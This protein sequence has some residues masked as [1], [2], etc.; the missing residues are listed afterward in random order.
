MI[1][2]PISPHQS[3]KFE[4]E[5]DLQN[6]DLSKECGLWVFVGTNNA[7][8]SVLL[9]NIQQYTDG[10][11]ISPS[12]FDIKSSENIPSDLDT[13]IT[14]SRK[15]AGKGFYSGNHQ[16]ISE[17]PTSNTYLELIN[18]ADDDLAELQEFHNTH[19]DDLLVQNSKVGAR[20]SPPKITI[21]GR[22][23][24]TAGTGSRSIL[25]LLVRLFDSNLK[26]ICIDEP[27]IGLEP[28]KQKRL[29]ALI[30]EKSKAKKNIFGHTF[31]PVSRQENHD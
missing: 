20:W 28:R 12:R 22:D 6:F 10:E 27:E 8:K 14:Q 3:N 30:G 16:D 31:K 2:L 13:A 26:S 5:V 24:S 11:Y 17:Y 4:L 18:L 15:P 21:G 29:A 9:K 25:H 7:K 1:D 23:A 19:F